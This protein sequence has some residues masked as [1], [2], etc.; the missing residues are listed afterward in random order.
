MIA[1]DPDIG[2]YL[3]STGSE[4]TKENKK[5]DTV[6]DNQTKPPCKEVFF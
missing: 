1:D 4:R 3:E 2:P 6:T 5:M